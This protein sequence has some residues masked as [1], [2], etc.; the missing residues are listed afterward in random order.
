MESRV[1]TIRFLGTVPSSRNPGNLARRSCN[2]F[3]SKL[4]YIGSFEDSFI[5][6]LFKSSNNAL[7]VFDLRTQ[8]HGSAG[9]FTINKVLDK[10]YFRY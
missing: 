1:K 2:G 6:E 7:F 9:L 4:I 8:G 10:K 5:D 3:L